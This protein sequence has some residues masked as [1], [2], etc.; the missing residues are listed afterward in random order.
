MAAIVST[1]DVVAFTGVAQIIFHHGLG[2]VANHSAIDVIASSVESPHFVKEEFNEATCWTWTNGGQNETLTVQCSAS[3]PVAVGGSNSEITGTLTGQAVGFSD[4]LAGDD[5]FIVP[6][7]GGGGG[8]QP[9]GLWEDQGGNPIRQISGQAV[10]TI[11][12]DTFSAAQTD[13][14]GSS[15]TPNSQRQMLRAGDWTLPSV[16]QIAPGVTIGASVGPSLALGLPKPAV[17][18]SVSTGTVLEVT[19]SP[20]NTDSISGGQGVCF[21]SI[22]WQIGAPLQLLGATRWHFKNCRFDNN[23]GQIPFIPT[24]ATEIIF[25]D[26]FFSQVQFEGG[27]SL[28]GSVVTGGSLGYKLSF[29]RCRVNDYPALVSTDAGYGPTDLEV[30]DSV[31][32]GGWPYKPYTV[33]SGWNTADEDATF[34]VDSLSSPSLDP[35][36][37]DNSMVRVWPKS[38]LGIPLGLVVSLDQ[39]PGAA[40]YVVRSDSDVIAAG[41]QVGDVII[42]KNNA[43][44]AVIEAVLST[45]NLR[46]RRIG[47]YTNTSPTKNTYA[48]GSTGSGSIIADGEALYLVKPVYGIVVDNFSLPN[49]AIVDRWCYLDGTTAPTPHSGGGIGTGDYSDRYELLANIFADV[50]TPPTKVDG[51]STKIQGSTFLNTGGISTSAAVNT[52]AT[53]RIDTSLFA[54]LTLDGGTATLSGVNFIRSGQAH[55]VVGDTVTALVSGNL[56]PLIDLTCPGDA[57]LYSESTSVRGSVEFAIAT[58]GPCLAQFTANQHVAVA[59]DANQ[60]A[61]LVKNGVGVS[62]RFSTIADS[63]IDCTGGPPIRVDGAYPGANPQQLTL[64][65]NVLT[66]SAMSHVNG[67]DGRDYGVLYGADNDPNGIVTAGIGTLYR[68]QG[69]GS[70]WAKTTDNGNN[71][72]AAL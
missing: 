49:T 59:Q 33:A 11:A 4:N 62:V 14:Q 71:N 25:E 40:G 20:S 68:S 44:A 21:D 38:N 51:T 3:R 58:T 37:A 65:D 45:N 2:C 72:W 29:I 28:A 5:G 9:A 61:I 13:S 54:G 15:Y 57:W 56:F 32:D 52:I 48:L 50:V 55:L 66:A 69:D 67:A 27:G 19:L 1:S 31:I 46:L 7:S 26:C 16:V 35:H 47:N 60:S 12:T 18:F 42:N 10:G 24:N 53:S 6:S 23:S 43:F 39:T 22:W 70:M 41:A 17:I 63:R 64:R 8:S 30:I 34:S 36:P